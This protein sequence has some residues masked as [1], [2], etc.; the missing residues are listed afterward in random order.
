MG[1]AISK[2]APQ[3]QG[4]RAAVAATAAVTVAITAIAWGGAAFPRAAKAGPVGPLDG[5]SRGLA[6]IAAT[7]AGDPPGM[8]VPLG[9]S[10]ALR[11][12]LEALD[13]SD[14]ARDGGQDRPQDGDRGQ[15][16]LAR[17]A[18]TP[19][20]AGDPA[21]GGSPTPAGAR[22]AANPA[23]A[24]S[25]VAIL[26]AV[27]RPEPGSGSVPGWDAVQRLWRAC[28]WN[29]PQGRADRPVTRGEL[30]QWLVAGLLRPAPPDLPQATALA[31]AAGMGWIPGTW[32]VAGTEEAAGGSAEPAGEP[33]TRR[34]L[35]AVAAAVLRN[36]AAPEQPGPGPST[37]APAAPPAPEG[38]FAPGLGPE[39]A[40]GREAA[41]PAPLVE[42]MAWFLRLLEATGRLFHGEGVVTA[43]DPAGG[44][45]WVTQGQ[46]RWVLAIAGDAAFY[47]NGRRAP[48][49]ALQPGDEVRWCAGEGG[50][51]AV[52]G[53][54][55]V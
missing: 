46:L 40:L 37:Q 42:T 21:T 51:T 10:A 39:N 54:A 31:M 49:E 41:T 3:R 28:G 30:A 24:G 6:Q 2:T 33:V 13:R 47:L 38:R 48:L 12:L 5:G 34:D 9:V 25:R 7:D 11:D 35:A 27:W 44:R 1:W 23:A 15:G 14:G 22:A 52:P 20:P 4:V 19:G 8:G 45:V 55:G 18:R 29:V 36:D 17:S 43:V 53:G 26:A 32:T 50:N 16:G